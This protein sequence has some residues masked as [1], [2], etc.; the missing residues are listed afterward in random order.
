MVMA[1]EKDAASALRDELANWVPL[2]QAA[3]EVG[4]TDGYMRR[5]LISGDPRLIGDKPAG[6]W[7][8]HRSCLPTF[9]E[10]LSSRSKGKRLPKAKR[11]PRSK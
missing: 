10:L 2:K 5:L 6:G 4:C 3:V 7:V 11:R 8:V 1:V 9:A